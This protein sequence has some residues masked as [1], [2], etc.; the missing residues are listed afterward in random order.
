MAFATA[1][2]VCG[3]ILTLTSPSAANPQTVTAVQG[4][5]TGYHAFSLTL[6]GGPQPSQGPAPVVTLASN[7]PNRL[8]I[9]SLS[10]G[11]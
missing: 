4:R 1:V 2:A 3:A 6:F 9:S 10:F 7:A 8:Q 5:A 11:R